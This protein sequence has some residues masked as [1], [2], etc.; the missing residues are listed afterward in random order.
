MY[1]PGFR[2]VNLSR[3]GQDLS[4]GRSGSETGSSFDQIFRDDGK[5]PGIFGMESNTS[6]NPANF[7]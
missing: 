7:L 3:L 5:N 4:L 6:N 2:G 1:D